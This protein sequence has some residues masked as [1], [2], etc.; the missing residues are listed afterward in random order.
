[1]VV[2]LLRQFMYS[3]KA[4]WSALTQVLGGCVLRGANNH[5][6]EVS[7]HMGAL[8]FVSHSGCSCLE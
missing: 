8:R 7:V 6:F 5:A 1:M 3:S 4:F 2:G